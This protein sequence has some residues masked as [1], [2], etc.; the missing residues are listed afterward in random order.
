MK[1]IKC[2][3]SVSIKYLKKKLKNQLDIKQISKT[4][5]KAHTR[6]HI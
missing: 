5:C 1:G 6:V 3:R 4:V 2:G